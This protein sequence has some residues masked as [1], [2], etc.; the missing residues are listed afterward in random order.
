MG[1]EQYQ[2]RHK[3]INHLNQGSIKSIQNQ[4]SR[5]NVKY[6]GSDTPNNRKSNFRSLPANPISGPASGQNSQVHIT[7]GG[8]Q[9]RKNVPAHGGRILA[10]LDA[11]NHLKRTARQ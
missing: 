3:L 5:V 2:N 4:D 1:V 7:L 6:P 9:R 11:K 8:G 10:S